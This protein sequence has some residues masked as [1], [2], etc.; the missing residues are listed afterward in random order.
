MHRKLPRY[1]DFQEIQEHLEA[2]CHIKV[3]E[4]G[5]TFLQGF[6]ET[7]VTRDIDIV[8][9]ITSAIPKIADKIDVVLG[10]LDYHRKSQSSSGNY[11]RYE[12]TYGLKLDVF[13]NK[14]FMISITPEMLSRVVKKKLCSEDVFLLKAQSTRGLDEDFRGLEQIIFDVSKGNFN[15]HIVIQE[16][17]QQLQNSIHVNPQNITRLLSIIEAVE[18]LNEKY[19]DEVPVL[20]INEIERIY[21]FFD[22]LKSD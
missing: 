17:E 20:F 2:Q 14:V 13:I 7:I 8:I 6:I 10:N 4:I 22:V 9:L 11:L 15:Y 1:K 5:G 18:K 21:T 3:F 19:P 12:T 16:L